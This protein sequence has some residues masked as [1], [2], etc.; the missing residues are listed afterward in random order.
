MNIHETT[1]I[2]IWPDLDNEFQ[3]SIAVQFVLLLILV[4]TIDQLF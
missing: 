3:F 1:D 2:W 4:R